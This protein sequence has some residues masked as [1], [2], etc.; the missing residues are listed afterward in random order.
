MG[1]AHS[2]TAS[3]YVRGNPRKL[4][5]GTDGDRRIVFDANDI[6]RDITHRIIEG[7]GKTQQA[8]ARAMGY[9]QPTLHAFLNGRPGKLDILTGLCALTDS[10]PV[11][12]LAEHPL[13]ADHARSLVRPKDHL[14]RRFSAA[15][16]NRNADRLVRALEL[17]KEAG[18]LDEVIELVLKQV[19][20]IGADRG[21][22]RNSAPKP[23][24]AKRS[25]K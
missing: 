4:E 15:L 19:D 24:T 8:A 3:E 1:K 14:F 13:Y 7:L 9:S 12:V 6:L 18:K 23:A 21:R 20:L 11:D 17:A 2:E 10:D 16:R 22:T 25:R 5:V